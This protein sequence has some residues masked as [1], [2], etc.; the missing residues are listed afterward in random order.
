MFKKKI[1]IK[2]K[3]LTNTAIIPTKA[4]KTDACFDLYL[5]APD[6]E[7]KGVKI[8]PGETMKL[9]SGIATDIPKGYFAAVFP[10]SGLGIN[11]NL[12][13]PNSTGIID[14]EY[15]G[16]WVI[17]L[18]ND[19]K[20]VRTLHHGDRIAQFAVLPV[21]NV[22]LTEYSELLDSDRGEG[23]LGSTGK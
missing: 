20:L 17:A 21:L 7:P 11:K 23:G 2:I 12:R 8:Q 13:L 16:E 6:A 15:R 4:H 22:T 10:R 9:H 1:D 14:S 5:D 18:H 3:R 19:G